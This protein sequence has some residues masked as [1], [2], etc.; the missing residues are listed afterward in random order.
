MEDDTIADSLLTNNE[1]LG[2]FGICLNIWTN[3]DA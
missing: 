1:S 3:E 2:S